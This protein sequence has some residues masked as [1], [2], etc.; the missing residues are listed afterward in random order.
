MDMLT[1]EAFLNT[2][3]QEHRELPSRIA[4]LLKDWTPTKL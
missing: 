4:A 3:I 2:Y 1:S